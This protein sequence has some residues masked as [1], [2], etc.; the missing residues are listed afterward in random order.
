M[1]WATNLTGQWPFVQHVVQQSNRSGAGARTTMAPLSEAIRTDNRT[2]SA[3]SRTRDEKVRWLYSRMHNK[4]LFSNDDVAF[5]FNIKDEFTWT[6]CLGYE[7][8]PTPREHICRRQGL[9]VPR[10]GCLNNRLSHPHML[11]TTTLSPAIP[12]RRDRTVRYPKQ[13]RLTPATVRI[14]TR[15]SNNN[16]IYIYIIYKCNCIIYFSESVNEFKALQNR[17]ALRLRRWHICMLSMFSEKNLTLTN[18]ITS[19]LMAN[20]SCHFFGS[21]ADHL[22]NIPK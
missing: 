7:S 5:P 10:G 6:A 18:N 4:A 12:L 20:L 22:Q 14:S 1:D 3:A 15:K 16:N 17:T 13:Y 2:I 11:S 21:P 8:P 19:E 9:S